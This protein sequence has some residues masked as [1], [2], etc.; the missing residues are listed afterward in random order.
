MK[1]LQPSM[2]SDWGVP[3]IDF[4]LNSNRLTFALSDGLPGQ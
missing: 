3:P 4:A 1:T 2:K